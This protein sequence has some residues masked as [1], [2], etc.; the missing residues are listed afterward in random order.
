MLET[1]KQGLFRSN[2]KETKAAT[3][4]EYSSC[5]SIIP[6]F[7]NFCKR[8]S[9]SFEM[10]FC[11]IS[12]FRF[13]ASFSF[14]RG[15]RARARTCADK[16]NFENVTK[17]MRE[18]ND[19]L[20]QILGCGPKLEMLRAEPDDHKRSFLDLFGSNKH[21]AHLCSPRRIPGCRLSFLPGVYSWAYRWIS[22]ASKACINV[23]NA[24]AV[25]N[26]PFVPKLAQIAFFGVINA[27]SVV[28]SVAMYIC[29]G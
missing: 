3:A 11:Y 2:L 13:F 26:Q 27:C 4:V 28:S 15:F 25:H 17:I 22:V 7:V 5:G 10:L 1:I 20:Q 14:F 23:D 12:F 16:R 21:S 19:L 9:I 8:K 18:D 29:I 6:Q 24:A